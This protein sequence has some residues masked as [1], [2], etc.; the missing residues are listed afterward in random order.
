MFLLKGLGVSLRYWSLNI[1]CVIFKIQASAELGLVQ[2]Q[3]ELG[4]QTTITYH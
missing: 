2:L 1:V 4:L 3:L